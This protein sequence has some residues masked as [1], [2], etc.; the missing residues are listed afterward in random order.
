MVARQGRAHGVVDAHVG[1]HPDQLHQ[2]VVGLRR[3]GERR[4][5]TPLVGVVEP[6]QRERAA[7]A[8]EELLPGLVHLGREVS[9]G[10]EESH[11][12]VLQES[13]EVERLP[14]EK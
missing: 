12:Q 1:Q 11:N 9:E 6:Q 8:L 3:G 4:V 14:T 10:E 5:A 7:L 13:S 2:H